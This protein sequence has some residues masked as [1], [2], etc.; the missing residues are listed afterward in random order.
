VKDKLTL[1]KK[2]QKRL[3]VL[4]QIEKKGLTVDGAAILLN[5]HQRQVWRLLADYR[6]EG[7][8]GLAHGNRGRQPVN[9]LPAELK[10]EII[11]LATA[12]YAGFN[13]TH[14]TEKL[15]ECEGIALSRSCVRSILLE[16]GIRSPR[17]RRSPQHRSR[18]ERYPREGMLLQTDG[19][20]HDWLEGR[21]PQLCLIG[22]ID[23]ATNKVPYALFQEQE[24][25][26]GYMRMVQEIVTQQGIPM[27]LY[28]DRHT[29]FDIAEAKLPSVE[30]QLDGAAPLTQLGRLLKELGIESISANSP[31]AKGRIERLWGTF[32]DRLT[33]ELRLAGAQTLEEANRVLAHFLP[34][35]NRKFAVTARDPAVAYR[36]IA[37]RFNPA[38]Y[39]CFKHPR[40]VGH[41]NVVRFERH[42]LQILPS[43]HRLSYAFCKVTVHHNL[44]GNLAVY[45]QGQLLATRPAPP[46]A[47]LLRHLA[48]IPVT[49]APVQQAT[50]R[51]R[52]YAKPSPDH[53]WRGKFRVTS[54]R[55][56]TDIFAKHIY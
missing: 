40:T 53:P 28:H 17:Q 22:A 31:Q 19:S 24:T 10:E 14:F 54:N 44:D 6:R 25:S 48:P 47:T 56:D 9:A 2:E 20:D 30:E 37:K 7:A 23:D 55:E 4:N 46:D 27:A 16:K 29:I 3:L 5:I 38:V 33:S 49:T 15:A 45:Y 36:K 13:H 35:Y 34:D 1:N 39:F 21:G 52:G 50:C 43:Q 18:R 41:D 12:K 11:V 8:A 26:A 32:Q 51:V 42:R